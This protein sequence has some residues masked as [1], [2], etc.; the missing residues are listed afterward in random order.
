MDLGANAE[1]QDGSK[2]TS[3]FFPPNPAILNL[4]NQANQEPLLH[5]VRQTILHHRRNGHSLIA[6]WK[7]AFDAG[8]AEPETGPYSLYLIAVRKTVGRMFN[9]NFNESIKAKEQ[10]EFG[11]PKALAKEL[12]HTGPGAEVDVKTESLSSAN[13]VRT[14][15]S[16]LAPEFL[17][18]KHV[19]DKT[20]GKL[21]KEEEDS[22]SA[23]NTSDPR[24]ASFEE[25]CR[26]L[27]V[28][29]AS[30]KE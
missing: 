1:A 15:F 24:L 8:H 9:L 20:I 5:L 30:S 12:P 17:P 18:R 4:I 11:L 2:Y 21:A 29:I 6:L 28:R 22:R 16:P 27:G 10:L 19:A 14:R 13:P 25:R 7:D 26:R 3:K 23:N